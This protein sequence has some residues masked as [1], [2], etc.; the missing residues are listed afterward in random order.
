V[1]HFQI[2]NVFSTTQKSKEMKLQNIVCQK[3]AETKTK[4]LLSSCSS[5]V[6]FCS[7]AI[8]ITVPRRKIMLPTIS[9][10]T[11]NMICTILHNIS[12]LPRI[13]IISKCGEQPLSNVGR[14][15]HTYAY[16][17]TEILPKEVR[18][19]SSIAEQRESI[20]VFLQDNMIIRI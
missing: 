16:S 3:P 6:N 7:I 2:A 13:Y 4:I 12:Q 18:V 17:I 8:L 19:N 1:Y 14:E 11:S 9:L 10:P 20:V 5:R 15:G